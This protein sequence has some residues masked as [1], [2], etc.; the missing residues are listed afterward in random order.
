MHNKSNEF[1]AW[2]NSLYM[3]IG[4]ELNATFRVSKSINLLHLTKVSE[5]TIYT[6][7]T[8]KQTIILINIPTSVLIVSK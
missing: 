2:C 4:I 7:V 8:S 1:E 6:A 5:E 3:F